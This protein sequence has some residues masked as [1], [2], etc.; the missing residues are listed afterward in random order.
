[1]A[2][3]PEKAQ[4]AAAMRPHRHWLG[5]VASGGIAFAVDATIL[6]IG[7]RVFALSP[8]TARLIAIAVAMLAGWLA[9]RRL[10]FAVADPPS[11]PEFVRY[12]GAAST[13]AI[14]NYGLYALALVMLPDLNRLAAL[15][16]AT[17][18]ALI[19]SYLAMRYGVFLK[20]SG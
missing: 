13:G 10:T 7:V 18:L 19:Y 1:M 11:L 8:Y 6:E 12:A 9:H 14:L 4:N 5:F 20:R 3:E 15:V 16:L 17:S 2:V